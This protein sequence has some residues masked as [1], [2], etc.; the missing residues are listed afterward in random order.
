M[1]TAR[2]F[3]LHLWFFDGS[4]GM[5]VEDGSAD[6][7]RA[8]AVTD[9]CVTAEQGNWFLLLVDRNFFATVYLAGSV[10]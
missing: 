10:D 2:P 8:A 1:R 5:I 4:P 7:G 6:D 3:S 9:G